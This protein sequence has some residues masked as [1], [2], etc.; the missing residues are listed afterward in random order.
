LMLKRAAAEAVPGFNSGMQDF[1]MY[2][3][4]SGDAGYSIF[5]PYIST[6]RHSQPGVVLL[7]AALLFSRPK[8]RAL[9]VISAVAAFLFAAGPDFQLPFNRIAPNPFYRAAEVVIPSFRRL[10]FPYRFWAVLELV[11]AVAVAEA[12]HRKL[13]AKPALRVVVAAVGVAVVFPMP[14][15]HMTFI[16]SV[17]LMHPPY[18]DVVKTEKGPVLD[19]P[20]LCSDEVI[21][22]QPFHG[23]PLLGGMAERV[24]ALRPPDLITR[25]R[26]DP[27]LDAVIDAG[28]G[29]PVRQVSLKLL[30]KTA[31]WVVLHEGLYRRSHMVQGCWNGPGGID[32]EHMAEVAREGITTILGPPALAHG[33]ASV[34]D[35]KH[36]KFER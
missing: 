14:D 23:S 10:L 26:A 12:V 27:V 32:G 16:S 25:I 20:F 11:T 18:I 7:V 9:L 30:T 8:L 6:I 1:S 19:L 17:E 2:L 35:L 4:R 15:K 33:E 21:H 29:L 22:Y 28:S 13:S 36:L 34:W 5:N 3:K 24:P 31:R